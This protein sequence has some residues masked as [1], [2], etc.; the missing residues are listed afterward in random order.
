M[1]DAER[2]AA[3]DF[4]SLK[5]GLADVAAWRQG[6]R[7]GYVE[8][9]PIDVKAIRTRTGKTQQAFAKAYRLPIGTVRDWEQSRRAPDAP[10][11]ALL[12]IIEADPAAAERLLATAE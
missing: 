7:A 3:E 9:A 8:H 11:R 5:R 4:E 12:S 6:A 10:A 2:E 1:T